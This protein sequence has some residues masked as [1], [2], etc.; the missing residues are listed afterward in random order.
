MIACA[1][2]VEGCRCESLPHH[3]Y[4]HFQWFVH[5][6]AR[7]GSPRKSMSKKGSEILN[8]EGLSDKELTNQ[9]REFGVELGPIV[10]LYCK[11]FLCV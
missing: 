4:V 6:Q 5:F 1:T 11:L 8:V 9:L 2:H 7:P 10:G 3:A